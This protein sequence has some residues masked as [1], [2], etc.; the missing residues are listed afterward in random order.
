MSFSL[1][2]NGV[3]EIQKMVHL[4]VSDCYLMETCH[5]RL[6]FSS[7]MLEISDCN[8]VTDVGIMDGVLTGTPKPH[9]REL[10]LGL[11]QTLNE[12]VLFR[13]SYFYENLSVLDLN[14]VSIAVTDNAMQHI[15]RH[16][17]FLRKLNVDSCCK[18]SRCPTT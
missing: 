3:R 13:L 10:S 9:L 18:V 4:T 11:L 6:C 15:L 2:D 1:T 12:P 14:G 16:M 5:M 17:R 7:Q 8:L